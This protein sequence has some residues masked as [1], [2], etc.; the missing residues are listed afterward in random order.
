MSAAARRWPALIAAS[1]G[2]HLLALGTLPAVFS[3]DTTTPLY[4][5]LTTLGRAGGSAGDAGEREGRH[6]PIARDTWPAERAA[7]AGARFAGRGHRALAYRGG[8]GSPSAAERSTRP[9]PAARHDL[10]ASR[11]HDE[12]ERVGGASRDTAGHVGA[13]VLG[14]PGGEPTGF[15]LGR[16]R[17]A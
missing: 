12:P 15:D 11:S 5:D 16:E 9:E 8:D 4:V 17:V 7:P 1:L 10:G 3:R 14:D 6:R 2:L 13:H